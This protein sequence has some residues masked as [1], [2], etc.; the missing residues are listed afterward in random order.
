M[1]TKK[2][3]LLLACILLLFSSCGGEK[4]VPISEAINQE[5]TVTNEDRQSL[6]TE[7]ETSESVNSPVHLDEYG[8]EEEI[9]P[10]GAIAEHEKSL[11]LY[12]YRL[13]SAYYSSVKT[14]FATHWLKVKSPSKIFGNEKA[15]CLIVPIMYQ[16][17]PVGATTIYKNTNYKEDIKT[18]PTST[19]YNI[20]TT[21]DDIG[22][23]QSLEYIVDKEKL[24]K[25][26]KDSGITALKDIKYVTGYADGAFSDF[27][28]LNSDK[29]EFAIPYLYLETEKPVENG[30]LMPL[31][32]FL[33]VLAEIEKEYPNAY[34]DK[35][36]L[37]YLVRAAFAAL[38]VI[39]AL[40]LL[41]IAF[42][43]FKA[44]RKKAKS[45]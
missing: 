39:P 40:I 25:L 4:A 6:K 31:Y 11:A 15:L 2:L 8:F 13:Y 10:Q 41:L 12:A 1:K 29:G 43:V 38:Y 17:K 22:H 5:F 37:Y 18:D 19:E 27:I 21:I 20:S 32:D 36:I 30:K 9:F 26:L 23:M 45:R 33:E 14:G 28:Y 42:F 24:A 44:I 7:M 34:P 35:N 16:G 3:V